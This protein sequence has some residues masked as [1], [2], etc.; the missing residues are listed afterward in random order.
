[1]SADTNKK[2]FCP[3]IKGLIETS[4]LDW[5][6]HMCATL[7][8]GGCNFRC[9]FCHNYELVLDPN[10]LS[11]WPIDAVLSQ[12]RRL[13]PWVEALCISGGEP[14]CYEDLAQLITIFKQEG[15]N[16]KLDT[17]G[18]RPWILEKL[19]NQCIIDYVAMDVKTI[20]DAEAYS[21]C[22]GREIDI[23]RIE[24]SI[25]LLKKSNIEHEFRL[26]ALPRLH[27]PNI[28]ME[29]AKTL[30][31]D[32]SKLRLQRFSPSRT[33]DPQFGHE[34]PYEETEFDKLVAQVKEIEQHNLQLPTA[35]N[36]GMRENPLPTIPR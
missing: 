20:I 19:L 6:G 3:P 8:L 16:I 7:F 13:R 28:I 36:K 11:T 26:T 31:G 18:Y 21:I 17:N 5:D 15:L 22:T 1:M 27:P 4:F 25:D 10:S 12:L 23:K 9:P 34:I 32:N 24:A 33:L 14:T 30:S 2:N 29:W 35:A